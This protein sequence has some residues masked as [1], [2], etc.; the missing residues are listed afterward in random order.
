MRP[1]LVIGSLNMDLVVRCRDLPQPG[2]TI[3][4]QDF[5]TAPGG[6]GANQAVAAA[7]LGARVTLA[8]CVGDDPFGQD[9]LDALRNDGVRPAMRRAP[10]P[11]GVALITVAAQGVNT[12][13]VA[14]GANMA[15]DTALVDQ[16]LAEPGG[17]GILLLQ[18]EIP[19]AANAHAISRA[20]AAGWFVMLNP[21]PARP[22]DPALLPMIDIVAPNQGE[23]AA[24][25]GEATAGAAARRLLEMGAGAAL[26]TLGEAGALYC[27]A[28][29]ALHCPAVLVEAVDTTAAGDAYIGALAAALAEDRAI[30]DCLGYAA[31]AAGFAVTQ[32]GAQPSLGSREE[33][34]ALR[35]RLGQPQ[36]MRVAL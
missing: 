1:V 34:A 27:S 7:R 12:I 6:K 3:L 25:T 10:G 13:V 33:V 16:A 26:I 14:S 31:V 8:G 35:H 17:P 28:A 19:E 24:L 20:R 5:F 15:C 23:A 11:T 30:A 18:H 21:A 9:L 2:E 32:L 29:T 4:G 36:P 22:L